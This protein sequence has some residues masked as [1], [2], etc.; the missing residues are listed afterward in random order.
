MKTALSTLVLLIT[1]SFSHAQDGGDVEFGFS[2]G[3]N[4]TNVSTISDQTAAKSHLGFNGG[5]YADY[6][7]SE[8]WSLRGRAYYNQNGWDDGFYVDKG[9]TLYVVNYSLHY[10]TISATPNWHF[11][12]KRKNFYLNLGPYLGVLVGANAGSTQVKDNFNATDI[13]LESSLGVQFPLT[14]KGSSKLFVELAGQAGFTDIFK[15]N[16]GD[17]VRN[18][19]NS[20]NIG[21]TF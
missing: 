4:L 7:F 5:F 11:G 18:R 3:L 19:K 10:V 12:G 13:G 20:L 9:G 8:R 16:E 15:D 21:I 1:F 14:Q 2:G 17:A 6:F